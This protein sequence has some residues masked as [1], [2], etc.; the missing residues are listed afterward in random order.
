LFIGKVSIFDY[1]RNRIYV[2]SNTGN[3]ILQI[4]IINNSYLIINLTT[5]YNNITNGF[6]YNNFI[7]LID[8]VNNI[9]IYNIIDNSLINIYN[10]PING[11]Y[12]CSIYNYINNTLWFLPYLNSTSAIIINLNNNDIT[13]FNLKNNGYTCGFFSINENNLNINYYIYCT[14][15]G[16]IDKID[17]LNA[18]FYSFPIDNNFIT[19]SSCLYTYNNYM[20]LI[21]KNNNYAYIYNLNNDTF[22]SIN[23]EA[24]N[25]NT[26]GNYIGSGILGLDSNNNLLIYIYSKNNNYNT[27]QIV[28]NYNYYTIQPINIQYFNS[29]LNDWRIHPN[30]N[31]MSLN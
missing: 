26:N 3:N 8:N 10:N 24:D 15:L 6:F 23:I 28:Q 20:Y 12:N 30:I 17:Y 25:C 22:K 27:S 9:F 5:I 1:L 31:K 2:F 18:T 19:I 29:F 21:Q 11:I 4:N 7:Y 16:F 14:R 13:T